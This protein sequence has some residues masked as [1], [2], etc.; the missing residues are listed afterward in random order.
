MMKLEASITNINLFLD[1]RVDVEKCNY[2]TGMSTSP[3]Y[4]R[5]RI[6]KALI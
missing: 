4:Y 3:F 1:V 5:L 2:R 6:I